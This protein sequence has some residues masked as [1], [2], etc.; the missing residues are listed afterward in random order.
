VDVP[1]ILADPS[2]VTVPVLPTR[3][4]AEE[5][6][7]VPPDPLDSVV[8]E[9]LQKEEVPVMAGGLASTVTVFKP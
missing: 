8:D 3:I 1:S 5:L 7:H 4:G 6:L 9:A 2:T